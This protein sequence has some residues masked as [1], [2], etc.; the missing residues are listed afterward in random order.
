M[1]KLHTKLFYMLSLSLVLVFNLSWAEDTKNFNTSVSRTWEEDGTGH[2]EGILNY[3]GYKLNKDDFLRYGVTEVRIRDRNKKNKIKKV[4]IVGIEFQN[5]EG[6]K[7]RYHLRGP[8]INYEKFDQ[9][10]VG[11]ITTMG[12]ELGGSYTVNENFKTYINLGGAFYTLLEWEEGSKQEEAM[13]R[14]YQESYQEETA[15]I[16]QTDGSSLWLDM[17]VDYRLGKDWNFQTFLRGNTGRFST[18]VDNEDHNVK[19]EGRQ[20]EYGISANVQEKVTGHALNLGLAIVNTT[21]STNIDSQVASG[22]KEDFTYNKIRFIFS[23]EW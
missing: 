21:I 17:K 14:V 4:K 16:S 19:V 8:L 5:P 2:T 3:K 7:V 12:A 15:A 18:Q 11:S 20:V 22:F 1:K 10:G 6:E 23:K 9:D 13:K